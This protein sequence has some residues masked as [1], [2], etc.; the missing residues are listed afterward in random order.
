MN[1]VAQVGDTS[2]VVT[3]DEDGNVWYFWQTIGSSAPFSPNQVTRGQK[4]GSA[5][6]V[7]GVGGQAVIAVVGPDQTLRV[8]QQPSSTIATGG[9]WIPTFDLGFAISQAPSIAQVGDFA[10]IA[11]VDDFGALW[12]FQQDISKRHW[13]PPQKVAGS[14]ALQSPSVARVGD[15][16]VI[17]AIDDQNSLWFYWQTIGDPTATWH[18]ELVDGPAKS[19]RSFAYPS[20]AQ[21][22]DASVVI[23][24]DNTGSLWSY[25]QTIGSSAPWNPNPVLLT[26]P[27][28]PFS[29]LPYPSIAQVGDSAVITAANSNPDVSL[30]FFWQAN[31]AAEWIPEGVPSGTILA[32]PSVAQVGNSSVIAAS[33]NNGDL[34]FFW[35]TIGTGGWNAESVANSQEL[36]G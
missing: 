30:W 36:G 6:S 8:Y 26:E 23:A 12:S 28:A 33:D 20:V 21:G 1:G 34:L 27:E 25:W 11:V 29:T 31:P 16:A 17:A 4:V 18:P 7:A 3:L 19:G 22:G 15:S 14:A 10:V 35:Q 24:V 32:S 13:L 5:P 9:S 2:A